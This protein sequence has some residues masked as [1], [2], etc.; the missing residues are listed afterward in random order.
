MMMA[1]LKA[2]L[3]V[4]AVAATMI[5]A[6]ALM[7]YQEVPIVGYVPLECP[8]E[9]LTGDMV[10]LSYALD[11]GGVGDSGMC[12]SEERTAG[13]MKTV[14]QCSTAAKCTELEQSPGTYQNLDCCSVDLCNVPP[15]SATVIGDFDGDIGSDLSDILGGLF[16]G[17]GNAVQELVDCSDDLV[18]SC[19]AAATMISSAGAEP[20]V[21]LNDEA[22]LTEDQYNAICGDSACPA[23]WDT[24]LVC[25]QQAAESIPGAQ[26]EGGNQNVAR[27]S[28]I[29]NCPFPP[30]DECMAR[31]MSN[32]GAFYNQSELSSDSAGTMNRLTWRTLIST[33]G[34]LSLLASAVA[35]LYLH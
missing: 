19:P 13:V 16:G 31:E 30:T 1:T 18:Q 5:P 12:T 10:C 23:A 11:C 4:A 17:L 24:Y 28:V 33:S 22:G 32:Q 9:G 21:S 26:Q 20:V 35:V 7:C 2:T 27:M 8:A 29:C 6:S 15:E 3:V 34:P 14:S 25:A